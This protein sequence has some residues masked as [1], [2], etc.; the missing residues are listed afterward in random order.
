MGM[1][2]CTAM[3]MALYTL[4]LGWRKS[5]EEQLVGIPE[6]IQRCPFVMGMLQ[7]SKSPEPLPSLVDAKVGHGNLVN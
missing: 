3:L 7:N 4:F 5:Y 1:A 6:S 2:A